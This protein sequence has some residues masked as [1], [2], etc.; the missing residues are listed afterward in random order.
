MKKILLTL[1]AILLGII[2]SASFIQSHSLTP[3]A[4][5]A[6]NA[7]GCHNGSGSFGSCT[8]SMTIVS[9]YMGL[10]F[11]NV[12][13]PTSNIQML[14]D[15]TNNVIDTLTITLKLPQTP[16]AG[17]QFYVLDN[18][19]NNAGNFF[20][21]N[22][23]NTIITVGG[24]VSYMSHYNSTSGSNHW[25]FKWS[26]NSS[27]VFPI[28]FHYATVCDSA[29]IS[30]GG[31][32]GGSCV[33]NC[34]GTSA[35]TFGGGATDCN[36]FDPHCY[37]TFYQT[38]YCQGDVIGGGVTCVGGYN[39]NGAVW[40]DY[41]FSGAG[42]YFTTSG[43][44]WNTNISTSSGEVAGSAS[45]AY[46]CGSVVMQNNQ[47]NASL[48][49]V[50][51][52]P[53]PIPA[54]TDI[55]ICRGQ[56]VKLG[57]KKMPSVQYNWW[58]GSYSPDTVYN[59]VA[60]ATFSWTPNSSLS[61]AVDSNPIATPTVTTQYIVQTNA[62]GCIAHDTQTVFVKQPTTSSLSA[63][64]CNG[65]NF[66]FHGKTFT[67]AGTFYD[68]LINHVGCDS[69]V[70]LHILVGNATA[71][72]INDFICN[73][74]I[75]SFHG[76]NFSTAGNYKDTISNYAGCD[77]II[78]LNLSVHYPSSYMINKTICNNQSYHFNG[79][80]LNSSGTYFDTLQ[81][82][83]GCDSLITLH[84]TVNPISTYT[85][86]QTIC[87]NQNYFFNG[88]S[89]NSSGTYFDTLT[90]YLGCDSFIT[91]HLQ[92]NQ[93]STKTILQTICSGNHFNFN[94][95]NL[96]QAGIYKDTLQNYAGCDSF[97]T[98]HLSVLPPIIA[99]TTQVICKNE[100]YHFNGRNLTQAGTYKDTLQNANGCDSIITLYLNVLQNQNFSLSQNLCVGSA[101]SF[102]GKNYTSAG[103]FADT[104]FSNTTCD[105]IFTI[106]INNLTSVDTAVLQQ[107][108][109]LVAHATNC[110]YQWLDCAAQTIIAG[111]IHDTLM[112][113]QAGY[114]AV[115]IATIPDNCIDTSSCRFIYVT[116]IESVINKNGQL[117]IYP[118]PTNTN[119]TISQLE[120]EPIKSIEIENVLVQTC[121]LLS[122]NIHAPTTIVDVSTL[123]SGIYFIKTT[124]EKGNVS[125]A[126]FVKE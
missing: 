88:H 99:S 12:G 20:I 102:H 13:A 46:M 23:T 47:H 119:L 92:V 95:K 111:A 71:S 39:Y 70:T 32:G 48:A 103:T 41:F 30:G 80:N 84:L 87:S 35:G 9:K 51:P 81:N 106:T 6:C 43:G 40:A 86:N 124:D 112:P 78:T 22:S 28:T 107:T 25:T 5:M 68:T 52:I 85:L 59:S 79:H 64:I 121:I 116:G 126:K 55:T 27:T 117:K 33:P 101:F 105:S 31:G 83:V 100:T 36:Y 91:L 89:L 104:I 26:P 90:N 21:V 93:I 2:Y 10:Q 76:S 14:Y 24:G 63:G 65:N 49:V 62:G 73:G 66:V 42:T 3:P 4:G 108:D 110:H 113:S 67:T 53:H 72:T 19:G 54:I 69:I 15:P 96:S 8:D 18:N 11:R 61:N 123:T 75:Y 16:I 29:A 115:I 98:L 97:V 60:F 1:V 45:Y 125:N 17:F 50:H 109:Q 120:N 38:D 44:G 94:G 74:K 56:P 82:S 37:F 57:S 114:Y 7:S 34:T 58:N 122:T 77:S 118:N